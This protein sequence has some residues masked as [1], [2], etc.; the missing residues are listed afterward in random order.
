M[1]F[2]D[3]KNLCWDATCSDSYSKSAIGDTAHTP[4][5]AAN[6]AEVRKRHTYRNLT[7][8]YR[9]EP[10]AVETTGALGESSGRF[11]SELGRRITEK[12]KDKRETHWLR[13][14][15]SIAVIRGNAAAVL[16]TGRWE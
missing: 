9:F 14:R 11:I 4:G 10:V 2:S 3:G 16:A 7:A 8:Q 13:Q 1:P 15:L 5:H 12:T 6:K